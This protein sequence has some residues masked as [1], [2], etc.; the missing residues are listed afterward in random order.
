M[1]S[2]QS[3]ISCSSIVLFHMICLEGNSSL[4]FH[5]IPVGIQEMALRQVT[6]GG[7]CDVTNYELMYENIFSF[8]TIC[9]PFAC[10]YFI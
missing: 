1:C 2:V 7:S 9:L 4:K 10:F 8:S 6:Q 3:I 5:L